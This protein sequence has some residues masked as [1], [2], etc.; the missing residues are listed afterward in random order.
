MKTPLRITYRSVA[1]SFWSFA[2]NTAVSMPYSVQNFKTIRLISNKV[3][4]NGILRNFSLRWV[5]NGYSISQQY[6]GQCT[7]LKITQLW[8]KFRSSSFIFQSHLITY[9]IGLVSPAMYMRPKT[10]SFTVKIHSWNIHG[11]AISNCGQLWNECPCH[12]Y[13]WP[14]YDDVSRSF[15]H[16]GFM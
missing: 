3:W 11:G 1:K 13:S 12:R 15:V 8:F 16:F 5:S 10:L 14:K 4:T 2:Q 7:G 9:S 6:L